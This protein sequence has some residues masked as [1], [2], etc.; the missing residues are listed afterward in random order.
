MKRIVIFGTGAIGCFVG[1]HWAAA[2]MDV[3]L[4]GRATGPERLNQAT[5]LARPT[6]RPE[7]MHPPRNVPSNAL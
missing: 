7:K 1:A 3:T 4:L 2:G 6:L 5:V